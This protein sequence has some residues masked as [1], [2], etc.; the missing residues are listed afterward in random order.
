MDKI[1]AGFFG[2]PVAIERDLK[3][4]F[5]NRYFDTESVLIVL[6]GE[7]YDGSYAEQYGKLLP[8]A[9]A[10]CFTK[11]PSQF[12]EGKRVI[13][14]HH[15]YPLTD[16]ETRHLAR[17]VG[18]ERLWNDAI[19]KMALWDLPKTKNVTVYAVNGT[20]NLLDFG[21]LHSFLNQLDVNDM[22]LFWELSGSANTEN[23]S[24]EK[25]KHLDMYSDV[26][27]IYD[28]DYLMATEK[29][30]REHFTEAV[31]DD[32]K[33]F[34][35]LKNNTYIPFFSQILFHSW[36]YK[37]GVLLVDNDKD[38]ARFDCLAETT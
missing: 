20:A 9:E 24:E 11:I 36:I 12:P 4:D 13:I 34:F 10:Y 16:T 2:S 31:W 1:V 7:S 38:T 17:E 21:R 29:L 37:Y 28:K 22:R 5:A 35:F 23:L 15:F 14:I 19:R 33:P 30:L 26:I 6:D 3:Q 27:T 32:G 25:L 8:D 18:Y